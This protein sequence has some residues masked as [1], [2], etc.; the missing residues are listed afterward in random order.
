MPTQCRSSANV[1]AAFAG[2]AWG[3]VRRARTRSACAMG[4][5][6]QEKEQRRVL[7]CQTFVRSD[8]VIEVD[9]PFDSNAARLVTGEAGVV[10]G[11]ASWLRR[12]I[13]DA[14]CVRASGAARFQGRA[15]RAAQGAGQRS[16]AQLLVRARA[17]RRHQVEFLIRL[18]PQARCRTICASARCP[19]DRLQIR[20]SKGSFHLRAASR[21]VLL[22][23]GG[24]GLSAVLAIAEQLVL[25]RSSR[26][27]E[28][29]YGVTTEADLVLTSRLAALASR[30]P[31]FSWRCIVQKPSAQWRGAVGVVTDLL[32][33]AQL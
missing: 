14:G 30:N 5:S 18:L 10:A 13:A 21:R 32:A 27:V 22:I 16:M 29:I 25:E 24:T 3:A 23:A 9:Y 11:G 8:C 33:D 4:L 26:P 28:L 15:V 7:T 12:S 31:G 2:P 20:G 19:G 6:Q 1:R 17:A